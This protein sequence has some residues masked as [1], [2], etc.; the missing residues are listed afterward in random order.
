MGC[1]ECTSTLKLQQNLVFDQDVSS[2]LTDLMSS[3]PNGNSQL[4]RQTQA[5]L[6]KPDHERFFIHGLQEAIA[7]FVVNIVEDPDDFLG[8]FAML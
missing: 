2:E 8:Q 3:K 6:T 4:T 7:E 1:F 5:C